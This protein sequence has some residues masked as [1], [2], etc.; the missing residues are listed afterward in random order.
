LLSRIGISQLIGWPIGT[1]S[2]DPVI[3]RFTVMAFQTSGGQM[4]TISNKF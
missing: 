3:C 4:N 2:A 1:I